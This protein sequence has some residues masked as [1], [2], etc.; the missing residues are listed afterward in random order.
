MEDMGINTRYN[1][2]VDIAKYYKED[3]IGAEVMAL[4]AVVVP[5]LKGVTYSLKRK[6]L[7]DFNLTYET[8]TLAQLARLYREGSGDYGICFEY[9]VHDAIL[10]SNPDV[11]NRIDHALIK[12]CKIKNGTPTS[13]LFGAEKT[14]AMQLI[15]SVNEHLTDESR[16][17]TGSVG[18]PIILKKHIQGVLNAFRKK[19]EREKLPNSINGLWKADLFVGKAEPDQWVGTTVKINPSQLEGA[20]GLRLA[21]IPADYGKSDK[22]YKNDLKNLIV[23]PLPY[24]Q[25][26][27]EIFFQGWNIVKT[28]LNADAQLPKEVLLPRSSDRYVCKELQIRRSFPVLDVIE[29]FE[30]LQQPGLIAVEEEEVTLHSTT[31]KISINQIIAPMTIN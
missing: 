4:Y 26:F 27:V 30:V 25:S 22:I 17:L 23:C 14:G 28:F 21:L 11:L 2:M 24:D 7:K 12:F 31:N 29:A 20:K 18:N 1:I 10:G 5:I 15:D 19:S 6:I 13:I 8:I 9:A 16:L 3:E